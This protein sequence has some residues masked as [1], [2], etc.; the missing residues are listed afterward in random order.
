[1]FR[2]I[3]STIYLDLKKSSNLNKINLTLKKFYKNDYFIKIY[4]TNTMLS[5]NNVINTNNCLISVCK[6]KFKNKIIILCAIDNL[7][8]GGGG[9]AVQNMNILYNFNEKE[10]L[11]G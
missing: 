7:I 5:T 10:G 1:M 8:K 4:K 6:S 2:G 3:L 11:I 9:Q